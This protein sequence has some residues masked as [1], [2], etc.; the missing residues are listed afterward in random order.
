MNYIIN[1]LMFLSDQNPNGNGTSTSCASYFPG[2]SANKFLGVLQVAYTVV[3]ILQI[4]VPIGLIIWGTL[5]FGKAVIEGDEKKMKEKRKPF[6]QRVISA[7]IVF[8]IPWLV[9][10]ILNNV[11]AKEWKECWSEVRTN[12]YMNSLL[13]NNRD[14]LDVNESSSGN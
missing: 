7:V 4:L 5:D 10:V 14:P 9:S 2:D 13:N 8:L 6:I 1:G 12:N 11:G 3:R